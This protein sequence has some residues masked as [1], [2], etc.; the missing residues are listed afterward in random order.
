MTVNDRLSKIA[1]KRVELDKQ[2]D[3]EQRNRE[4]TIAKYTNDIKALA[5]RLADLMAI[6]AELCRNDIPL[7]K[8]TRGITGFSE[9]EFETDGIKHGLGFYFRYE[10]GKGYLIGVGIKGGGC[11]GNNL[12]VDSNGNIIVNPLERV[13]GCWTYD[14]AYSDF[15]GKCNG[16]LKRF[17]DFERRVNEYVDNL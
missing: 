4:A 14:K 6:A 10:K 1:H 7:G 5:P 3:N 2:A 9:D 16:F 11:C 8:R 17:D 12:A 13:F 15:V